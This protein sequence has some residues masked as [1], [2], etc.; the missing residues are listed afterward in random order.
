LIGG[1]DSG[2]AAVA[3][4]FNETDFSFISTG[5]GASLEFIGGETLPGIESIQNK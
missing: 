3:L 2:A 1:G 4:G 5:G